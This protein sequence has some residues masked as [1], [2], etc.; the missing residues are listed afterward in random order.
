VSRCRASGE[1]A[2]QVV[3][4]FMRSNSSTTELDAPSARATELRLAAEASSGAAL[5]EEFELLYTE[6]FGLV[7]RALARL[8]TPPAALEDATQDVFLVVYR[9]AHEF[10][11][12][13]SWKTWIYGIAVHVAKDHRRAEQR[14]RRR[15]E[16]YVRSSGPAT[17]GFESTAELAEQHQAAELVLKLLAEMPEALREVLVLAELEQLSVS[18]TAKVLKLGVRTTQRR[19]SGARALF[20]ELLER[21]ELAEANTRNS[22]AEKAV[23]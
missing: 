8:G 20:D 21:H 9:R 2:T 19:L 23:P 10:S 18:E 4:D 15:I 11:K 7:W 13:S 12:L 17:S 22:L 14:H 3:T 16:E 1:L 5:G 6:H